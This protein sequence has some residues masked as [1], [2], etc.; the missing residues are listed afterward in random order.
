MENTI[1]QRCVCETEHERGH[2][3]SWDIDGVIFMGKGYRGLKPAPR[4]IIITGRSWEE[5]TETTAMLRHFGI[6]HNKIYFNPL[7]FDQKTRESSGEHKAKVL[8]TLKG[9]GENVEIHFED[10]PVQA[11]IIRALAPHV[12]V[13]EI[14]HNLVEKENVRHEW[15]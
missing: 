14:V 10:D 11:K 2:L 13:V 5:E 12:Q 8:N 15:K 7:P 6:L 1:C 4:D 3:N 9:Y